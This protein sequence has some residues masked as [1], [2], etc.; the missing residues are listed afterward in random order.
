LEAVGVPQ[1]VIIVISRVRIYRHIIEK[2]VQETVQLRE[3]H[4]RVDRHAVDQAFTQVDLAQG[5]RGNRDWRR[6]SRIET[7]TSG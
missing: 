6:S 2:P 1:S 7:C 5:D 3:E 4:L